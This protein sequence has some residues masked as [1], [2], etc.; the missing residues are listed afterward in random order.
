M[1]NLLTKYREVK[2]NLSQYKL[3]VK[4]SII[5][6]LFSFLLAVIILCGP[7]AFIINCTIFIEYQTLLLLG[8]AVCLY[9]LIFLSRIFYFM[10]I[11]KGRIE[12]MKSFFIVEALYTLL[13]TFVFAIIILF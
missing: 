10:G 2:E 9:F 6:G 8:L 7:I 12:N 11:S 5:L 3:S 13:L 1:N 4:D